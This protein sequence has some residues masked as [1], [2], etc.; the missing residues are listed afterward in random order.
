MLIV[1]LSGLVSASSTN[2]ALKQQYY[3]R[4]NKE[5]FESGYTR[6]QS[7]LNQ[8]GQP[9]W[10]TASP[11]RPDSSCTG[12]P[13]CNTGPTCYVL[14]S[15]NFK[16]TYT[17]NTPTQNSDGSYTIPVIGELQLFRT[18][19][20]TSP[21]QVYT[22]SAFARSAPMYWRAISSGTW[23]TCGL[24]LS[25]NPALDKKVKC[26]GQNGGGYH[27]G[28]N[29][30][31]DSL[32]PTDVYTGGVLNGLTIK[33]LES[34]MA[35]S[36]VIASDDNVYCWGSN[37]QY[38]LG[39]NTTTTRKTPVAVYKGG[40]LNGLTVKDMAVG[41]NFVGCVIASDNKAYC[42]GEND[43]GGV[44][45][46]TLVPKAAPVAVY[47]AG[48]L[49]GKSLTTIAAGVN[50]A[51]ALDTAGLAYCWGGTSLGNGT[52]NT[53]TIPVAVTMSGVLSGK[54]ITQIGLGNGFGCV[55]ASD[56]KPYCWGNNWKG[57]LG[58]GTVTSST[59]PVAV[60][61]NGAL[62]G[63]T[64]TSITVGNTW[65]CVLATDGR[66]Y[67][68]GLIGDLAGTYAVNSSVPV[69]INNTGAL[70]GKTLASI[71]AGYEQTCALD[72]EGKSY[73]W[74]GNTYGAFG[75]GTTTGSINPVAT[76]NTWRTLQY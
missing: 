70:S 58:N 61:S 27:F 22:N 53:S 51:C 31:D 14:S 52:N 56:N 12:G 10:S 3:N 16:T 20:V 35:N 5:A 15:T 1:L 67:C 45:D 57:N 30:S 46:N 44:G 25:T 37:N 17:V 8:F 73:C 55:L 42:W 28:N 34:T 64:L 13:Q 40:V 19:S 18:S 54:T 39:D 38:G 72:V 48:V 75:N 43:Y 76:F 69:A 68:W 21:S 62:N 71:S 6:A 47:T 4:L 11:L 50:T 23:F 29:S 49:S 32:F 60:T 36:C 74:G 66:A 63:K 65:A 33:K 7:C 2:T 26:W 41:D 59:V 24:T 9:T